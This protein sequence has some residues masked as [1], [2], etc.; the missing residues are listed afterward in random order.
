MRPNDQAAGRYSGVGLVS[1]AWRD[2]AGEA[3]DKQDQ[4]QELQRRLDRF[5]RDVERR[6]LRI[7]QLRTGQLDEALDIVQD[8]MMRFAT[9]YSNKPEDQWRPLFYKVLSSRIADWHRKRAVRQ[10]WQVW[11]GRD[12]EQDPVETAPAPRQFDP[13]IDVFRSESGQALAEALGQLP[14]RQQQA[15]LLRTWEGLSVKETATAMACSEG[16]VKTHLSRAMRGMRQVLE[17]FQ[18]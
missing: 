7:A 15:F 6:A 3:V 16:S 2:N 18:P 8:A 10:R 11:R 12:E 9:R 5:L 1:M 4:L 13:T 14:A 17:E